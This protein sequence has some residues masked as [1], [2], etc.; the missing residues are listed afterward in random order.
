MDDNCNTGQAYKLTVKRGILALC[1]MFACQTLIGIGLSY[2]AKYFYGADSVDLPTIGM[3]SVLIGG[4]LVLLWVWSDIRRFGP[5]FLPQIGLRKGTVNPGQTLMLIL[6][7]L[8]VTHFLAWIYRSVLLPIWDQGGIVGGGSQMFAHIQATGS[9]VKMTAFLVLA[10]VVGPVM[11]E[12][13]FRGYLQSSLTRKMPGWAAV[14][15]ASSTG[16]MP[17]AP[18]TFTM[19]SG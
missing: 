9:V 8:V 18:I 4:C 19:L 7:L 3:S 16:I 17:F 10:L 15:N 5:L 12:V 2:W 6:L 1:I 13:V 14:T 11:E